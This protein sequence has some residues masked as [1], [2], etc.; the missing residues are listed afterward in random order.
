MTILHT[1]RLRLEPFVI[2]H[3]DGLNA[4]AMRP[5]VMRYLGGQA[6]TREQTAAGIARVRR[7]WEIFGTRW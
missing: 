7:N 5:E 3:L 2:A 4:M 6:E 1:A